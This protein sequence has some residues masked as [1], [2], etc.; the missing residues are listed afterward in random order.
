MKTNQ[1]AVR[2]ILATVAMLG[3]VA[4]A[5]ETQTARSNDVASSYMTDANGNFYRMVGSQKCQ[6][7]TNVKSFKVSKHPTDLAM[8]Y[9]VRAESNRAPLYVLLNAESTGNCPK[10]TK[11]KIVADVAFDADR[12]YRYDVVEDLNTTIVR[13]ALDTQGNFTAAGAKSKLYSS[14]GVS[15]YSMNGNYGVS[16]APFSSY[17]AFAISSTGTIL[18]LKGKEPSQSKF[19]AKAFESLQA[20]KSANNL[21]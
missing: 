12:G 20:F 13:V 2:F 7:T 10:A 1:F 15:D 19:D 6:I 11:T 4:S 17:V 5:Q 21:Q 8:V 16:G 3:G 18:K 14:A 9:Y